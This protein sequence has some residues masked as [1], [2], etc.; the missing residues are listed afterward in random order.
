[1]RVWVTAVIETVR[2]AAA[3]LTFMW[4]EPKLEEYFEKVP[5]LGWLVAALL[6]A[7]AVLVVSWVLLPLGRVVV[8]VERYENNIPYAGPSLDLVCDA[9]TTAVERYWLHVRHEGYGL[10]SRLVIMGIAKR[11]LEVSFEVRTPQLGLYSEDI[12]ADDTRLDH[13]VVLSLDNS[14][15]R[16]SWSQVLVS[17][18]SRD[19]PSSREVDVKTRLHYPNKRPWYF[20]MAWS[21]CDVKHIVLMKKIE[22]R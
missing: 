20:F 8:A 18:S 14:A 3:V 6:S 13:G 12:N 17:V 4:L 22:K 21:H 5:V 9:H 1:M 10:V 11:G 15:S 16:T 7:S 19:V 2:L